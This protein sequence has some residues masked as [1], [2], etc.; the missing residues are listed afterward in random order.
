MRPRRRQRSASIHSTSA[1]LFSLRRESA[2]R[3]TPVSSKIE[4]LARGWE[5]VHALVDPASVRPG[6]VRAS[7]AAYTLEPLDEH[8]SSSECA[9]DAVQAA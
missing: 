3:E 1:C 5:K 2:K 8:T 6:S 7:K 4:K 9:V